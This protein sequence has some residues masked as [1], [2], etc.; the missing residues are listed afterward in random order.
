[1]INDNSRYAQMGRIKVVSHR[2]TETVIIAR[3]FLPPM[4]HIHMYKTRTI[5]ME[6]RLDNIANEEL[7]DPKRFWV[8]A[9]ANNEMNPSKLTGEMGRIIDIGQEVIGI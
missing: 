7:G 9:D 4:K 2:G 5:K 8:V 3:R 6:D 1:M